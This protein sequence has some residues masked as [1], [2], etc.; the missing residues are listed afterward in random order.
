MNGL[1]IIGSE[2]KLVYLYVMDSARGESEKL[3]SLQIPTNNTKHPVSSE[4]CAEIDTKLK[5][6]LLVEIDVY[7]VSDLTK[8]VQ[9]QDKAE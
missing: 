5:G 7:K 3:S 1:D 6:G 9:E 2:Y 4:R 8:A